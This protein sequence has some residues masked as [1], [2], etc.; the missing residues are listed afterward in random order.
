MTTTTRWSPDTCDCILEYEWDTQLT[1]DT[2]THKFTTFIHKCDSHAGLAGDAVHYQHVL[3]EN[4]T[5]NQFVGILITHVPRLTAPLAQTDG[6][7]VT[8]L[9]PS[10]HLNWSFTG[11]DG[12]RQL[13]VSLGGATLTTFE[14]SSL[15][16]LISALGKP[17]TL[18]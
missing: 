2:R 5:K 9:K 4:K 1:E 10:V 18:L 16:A 3:D 14:A 8:Q 7:I 12:N 15:S 17:V 13:L 11:S 6:T